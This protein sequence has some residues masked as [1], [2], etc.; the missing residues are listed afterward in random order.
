MKVKSLIFAILLSM[1][2][3]QGCKS[4]STDEVSINGT[5]TNLPKTK[6]YIYQLLPASKPLLDSVI[7][8]AS[9]NFDISIPVKKAGYY[10]LTHNAGNEITIVVAPG[11]KIVLSGNGNSMRDTYTVEGSADSKLYCEYNKFT[12]ANLRRVDSLSRIF[13]ESQSNPDFIFVK[14]KLDSAYLEI[15]SDQ[16]NKVSAFVDKHSNSLA[17]LLVISENFGP[18]ELLSEQTHPKLFLKL[19]STL[20]AAY[21]ENSLVNTFHLRMLQFKAERAD[22]KEHDKILAPGNQAPEIVL[23]NSAGKAIKLSSMHGKLTLVYFWSSWNALCRQTNM[24][25]A[26]IYTQY[27]NRGF[28]IY[29]VSIDSDADLWKKSYMLDKA[30]WIQVNY[31]KGLESDYSKTYEVKAIPYMILIGKEGKIIARNPVFGELG[32]L[33]KKNL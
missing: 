8:D 21:P 15:F 1:L 2:L 23:C 9:G 25:L 7:T 30:Y 10:T 31:P 11:E 24:N 33:I 26:T 20:F 27:H 14:K 32:E 5:F 29:A 16:K 4:F 28:E 6:L 17:S 3:F 13:A 19:D 22:A 18:N 12:A